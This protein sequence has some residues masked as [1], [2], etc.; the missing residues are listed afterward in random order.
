MYKYGMKERG[1]SI[2]CQPRGVIKH[3]DF[4]SKEETGYWSI[5]YYPNPL[6]QVEVIHYRLDY[7]GKE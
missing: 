5:I 1:F 2:G 4:K 6:N 7:L 3:E